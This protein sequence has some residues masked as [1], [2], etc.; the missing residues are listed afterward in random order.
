VNLLFDLSDVGIAPTS[1]VTHGR[2]D[3]WGGEVKLTKRLLD[4]HR[5]TLGVEYRDNLHQDQWNGDL[6][7]LSVKLDA[8]RSSQIWALY[9]QDEFA[10]R[11]NLTLN[12][13]GRYDHY[14]TFGGTFNPRLALIYNFNKKTT[15]KLLY[16]EAFRAP[17]A[18]ELYYVAGDY[19][20]PNPQLKPETITTYEAILERTLGVHFH[21][22][23]SAYYYTAS[24][25]IGLY[26]NPA[27]FI[28]QFRNL[29]QVS[30]K[31]LEFDLDGKWA[32]GLEGHLS[33]ALQRTH[34]EQTNKPLT[35]SPEHLVKVNL[36]MPLLRDKLFAGLEARYM[37]ERDTLIGKP[38]SG[39]FLTNLT[40]FSP[41][42]LKGFEVSGSIYNLFDQQYGDPGSAEHQQRVIPQDGR[43]FWLKVK[44]NF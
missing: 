3:W 15:L 14:D 31:G 12:L 39:V 42:L 2:G 4:K 35:N 37:S 5:L 1:F 24:E 6:G 11:D 17:N 44:Y 41:A 16:G 9:V 28:F 13:G 43:T 18:Y 33:Y 22:S 38:A 40:L 21:G 19:F 10:V 25:L 7:P 36:I 23:V 8:R 30:A 20:R 32:S 29:E 27:E 26:A 34:N